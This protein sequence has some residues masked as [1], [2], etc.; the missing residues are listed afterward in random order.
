M[1]QR[2]AEAAGESACIA[3]TA[4]ACVTGPMLEGGGVDGPR[5]QLGVRWEGGTSAVVRP[6]AEAGASRAGGAAR[7]WGW[8]AAVTPCRPALRSGSVHTTVCVDR[9]FEREKK[10]R[11][12][13]YGGRWQARASDRKPAVLH[14]YTHQSSAEAGAHV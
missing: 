8:D 2:G 6:C 9:V 12:S 4:Y 1:F 14:L 7:V 10:T 5:P 3:C 13:V 11:P